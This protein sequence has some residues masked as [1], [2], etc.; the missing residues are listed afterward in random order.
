MV[1]FGDRLH[2]MLQHAVDAV[3]DDHR[4]VKRLDVDVAGTAL[5]RG[6]DGGVYQPDDR[7]YVR[8]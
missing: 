4:I 7:T 8:L 6:K 5:E 2:G 1:F 3:F